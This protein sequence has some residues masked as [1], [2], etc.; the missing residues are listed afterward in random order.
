MLGIGRKS[1]KKIIMRRII[2]ISLV[3]AIVLIVGCVQQPLEEKAE[4]EFG[5]SLESVSASCASEEE[6]SINIIQ[7]G[8]EL[9]FEGVVIA[10]NPCQDL[11]VKDTANGDKV[12]LDLVSAPKGGVCIQCIGAVRFSG[13]IKGADDKTIEFR[14]NSELI[15][16]INGR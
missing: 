4:Q 2:L 10:P 15:D 6:N 16:N 3:V 12:I 1:N 5:A 8:D 13:R 14:Y 11:K 7:I 9:L